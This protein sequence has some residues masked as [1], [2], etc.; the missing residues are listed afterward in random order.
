MTT[1]EK[2]A[3]KK[4]GPEGSRKKLAGSGQA[5][6]PLLRGRG[7]NTGEALEKKLAESGHGQEAAQFFSRLT[8]R[9]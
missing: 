9:D 1:G 8:C 4:L 3:W 6:S 2:E 5:G 7:G